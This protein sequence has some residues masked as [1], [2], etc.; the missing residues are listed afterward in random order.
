MNNRIDELINQCSEY[1]DMTHDIFF[2]KNKFAEL[3]IKECQ[4]ALSPALRD[5]ISRG[6]ACELINQHFEGVL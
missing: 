2:D 4:A 3:I 1:S 5:M 6:H